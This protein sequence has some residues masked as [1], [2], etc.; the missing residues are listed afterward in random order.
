MGSFKFIADSPVL[1]KEALQH[2]HSQFQEK[3][4]KIMNS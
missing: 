3:W 4:L 1:N 2:Q